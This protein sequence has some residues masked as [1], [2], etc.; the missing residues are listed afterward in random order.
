METS[1]T[2]WRG[3]TA[4]LCAWFSRAGNSLHDGVDGGGQHDQRLV[5][6]AS[7][8]AR[9]V[10]SRVPRMRVRRQYG[11]RLAVPG[12]K[13]TAPARP[14]KKFQRRAVL[15]DAGVAADPART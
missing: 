7:R 10:V 4:A 6:S 11:R 13:L 14:A 12:R 15:N 3:P 1:A 9:S 5:A 8:E 2:T